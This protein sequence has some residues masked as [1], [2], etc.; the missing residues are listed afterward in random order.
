MAPKV[1]PDSSRNAGRRPQARRPRHAHG[2]APDAF[3]AARRRQPAVQGAGARRHLDLGYRRRRGR[4]SEPDH[5]LLPH[6]GSAV[7]RSRLPRHAL[8]GA[9]GRAG[10]AA[11]AH[12]ARLHPRAGRDRDG[13]G[14]GRLLC[15]SADADAPPPGSR[16][17]GGA[18]HRAAARR[19]RCAPMPARS[20]GTAGARCA[21]PT[22]PRGGSGRSRSA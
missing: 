2:R 17:A 4:V 10:G 8:S 15:R 5:L 11:G 7:R 6:Q 16:A 22:Q 20:S 18:H 14:F 19:R 13:D 3:A 12:A 21:I 1:R 9:R